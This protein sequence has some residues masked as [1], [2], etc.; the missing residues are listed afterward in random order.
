[1]ISI[2]VVS[3]YYFFKKKVDIIKRKI[4]TMSKRVDVKGVDVSS[5]M[6]SRRL[7]LPILELFPYWQMCSGEVD[8]VGV[9]VVVDADVLV[10]DVVPVVV[11]LFGSAKNQNYAEKYRINLYRKILQTAAKK[12]NFSAFQMSFNE[13]NIIQE[14]SNTKIL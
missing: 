3:N 4:I 5:E 1:M 13:Y 11:V 14:I 8:V 7:S 10:V 9:E 6:L 12:I 2:T